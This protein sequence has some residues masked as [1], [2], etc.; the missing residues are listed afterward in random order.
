MRASSV[1]AFDDVLGALSRQERIAAFVAAA[2]TRGEAVSSA[3]SLLAA[4]P[5][6]TADMPLTVRI[7]LAEIARDLADLGSAG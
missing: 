1:R 2:V 6:L 5:A 3:I 4:V 7:A